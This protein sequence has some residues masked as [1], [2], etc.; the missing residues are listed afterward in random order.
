M[1]KG[2]SA[3]VPY[4]G[5]KFHFFENQKLLLPKCMYNNLS[6]V[7]FPSIHITVYMIDIELY[8]YRKVFIK[9]L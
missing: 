5:Q 2:I 1:K 3:K 9:L 6:A 7:I 8:R 4:G